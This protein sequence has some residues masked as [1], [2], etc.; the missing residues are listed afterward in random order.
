MVFSFKSRSDFF[1]VFEFRDSAPGFASLQAFHAMTV[2][3]VRF[4]PSGTP[5]RLVSV[6]LHPSQ[7]HFG[8]TFPRAWRLRK[9]DKT[10]NKP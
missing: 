3:R 1:G 6:P 9:H 8:T 4:R 10:D 7:V 5:Y 2:L